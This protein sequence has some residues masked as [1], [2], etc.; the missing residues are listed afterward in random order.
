MKMFE[1]EFKTSV[2]NAEDSTGNWFNYYKADSVET[3]IALF[4]A[5]ML[6]FRIKVIEVIA[7][8]EM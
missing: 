3:A 8:R 5:D 4:H 7:I 6:T 2:P 1:I